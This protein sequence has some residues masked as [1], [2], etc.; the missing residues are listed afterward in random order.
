MKK[1]KLGKK[2]YVVM[3]IDE[4]TDTQ[5]L[6]YDM[7]VNLYMNKYD[8]IGDLGSINN[9]EWEFEDRTKKLKRIISILKD[10]EQ[11]DKKYPRIRH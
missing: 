11:Y 3:D 9:I 4:Y 5:D 6:I 7:A 10:Y 2:N 1:I 8:V